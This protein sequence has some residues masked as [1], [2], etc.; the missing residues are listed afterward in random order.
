MEL[1]GPYITPNILSNIKQR[2]QAY[3][4]REERLD[5]A[6]ARRLNENPNLD[7]TLLYS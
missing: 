2:E 3:K 7:P 5:Q 1:S 4:E 6:R